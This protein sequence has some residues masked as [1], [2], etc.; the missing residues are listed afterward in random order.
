M[1]TAD[2]GVDVPL[3]LVLS[4]GA[5]G[6]FPQAT[7]YDSLGIAAAT[8]NLTHTAN[9]LYQGTFLAADN[10]TIGKFSILYVVYSDAG[11]TTV[12]ETY[13]RVDEDLDV[14]VGGKAAG[15]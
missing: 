3:Q 14:T 9:G 4:D 11:H 13:D 5:T 2:L 1:I 10:D 12:D 8:V 7:I 6:L 15:G